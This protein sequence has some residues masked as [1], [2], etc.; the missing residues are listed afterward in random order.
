MEWIAKLL[1]IGFA[2]L[3]AWIAYVIL[4]PLQ[5][6]TVEAPRDKMSAQ[7]FVA[8]PVAAGV[9]IYAG[10]LVGRN[11]A[12]YAK[13][14]EPGDD[15]AGIAWAT[16]D[17]TAGAAGAINARI[18]TLGDFR[19]P[20]T[21]IAVGDVGKPVFATGDDALALLGHTDAFVGWIIAKDAANNMGVVRL[22]RPGELPPNGAGH[23]E[24]SKA[25]TETFAE[26]LTAGNEQYIGG[27]RYDAIGA[28]ILTG[29]GIAPVQGKPGVVKMLLD[30]D[31]EAENLTIESACIFP[32]TA[33]I[34]AEFEL[35]LATAGGAAT[36]DFDFGIITAASSTITDAIRANI[37]VNTA[38]IRLCKFHMDCNANDIYAGSDDDTNVVAATDTTIDNS[39]AD[40]FKKFKIVARTTGVCELWVDSGAGYVR[41]LSTTT[42]SVGSAA[43]FFGIF[44]NLEKSTGTGVPEVRV[45][46]LRIAGAKAA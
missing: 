18:E 28:G 15:F 25:F 13:P 16:A 20:L 31:N 3:S 21:G 37:D 30:N 45:R 35:H 32:V 22:R 42:F 4:R 2:A 8:L 33:G 38:G 12:G 36:D 46:R 26:V 27:L 40:A 34:T 24:I 5:A 23:F 39:T 7:N 14:F 9:K 6:L 10:A 19:L 17:N 11:P 41:V 44:V 43:G 29:A 1:S